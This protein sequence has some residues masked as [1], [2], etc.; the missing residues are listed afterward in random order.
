M[1]KKTKIV[2]GGLTAVVFFVANSAAAK[3]DNNTIPTGGGGAA[4]WA[5]FGTYKGPAGS[6]TES[7]L[8]M[9]TVR[10]VR[11]NNVGNI[12]TNAFVSSTYQYWQKELR[13][14][15]NT[16]G[17]FCQFETFAYGLRAMIKLL[18]IYKTNHSINT[19]DSL[20]S[21]WDKPTAQ[22]YKDFVA[23][24][25]GF[26]VNGIIDLHDKETLKKLVV[27]MVKLECGGFEVTGAQFETAY[28]IL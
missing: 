13:K 5:G 20:I 28:N 11:N 16:D 27:A 25:T 1:Q 22:H 9:K 10:G 19:I 4:S 12:K 26:S 6:I 15:D 17:V 21:R 18:K 8:G 2:L 7:Y 23:T 3:D 24:Q 14:E